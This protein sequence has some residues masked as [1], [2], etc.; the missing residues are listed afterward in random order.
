MRAPRPPMEAAGEHHAAALPKAV[1]GLGDADRQALQPARERPRVVGFDQEMQVVVLN[2]EV[3]AAQAAA[4]LGCEKRV[5]HCV[6][7]RR[8]AQ[9]RH[10][11]QE[12]LG[13]MGRLMAGQ[14]RAGHVGNERPK[15]VRFPSGALARVAP[16]AEG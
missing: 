3:H 16:L 13:H 4:L 1:Q 15:A 10:A 6:G 8:P 11:G 7:F 9:A 2:R 12:L 5:H 14:G